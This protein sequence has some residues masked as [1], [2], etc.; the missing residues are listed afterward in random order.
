MSTLKLFGVVVP[1]RPPFYKILHTRH[2]QFPREY[3]FK[4]PAPAQLI[5]NL[6]RDVS[7]DAA[8]KIAV[9]LAWC[10][11]RRISDVVARFA[12]TFDPLFT[13][14]SSDIT[15]IVDGGHRYA[16]I[17]LPRSKS[18]PFN[19]GGTAFLAASTSRF[20]LCPVAFLESFLQ[21]RHSTSR[22]QPLC[23]LPSGKLVTY[24][25]VMDAIKA[26]AALLGLSAKSFATQ[27]LRIGGSTALSSAGCSIEDIML[28]GQWKSSACLRYLRQSR[29]RITRCAKALSLPA[30]VSSSLRPLDVLLTSRTRRPAYAI[31][32]LQ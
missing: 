22:S 7:V 15:F 29:K 32:D 3:N 13:L 11:T 5:T 30:E 23:V 28:A 8:V 20:S 1:P 4:Q 24:P 10:L 21:L 19:Q 27:S 12:T 31:A 14:M 18:D 26:H 9:L 25:I 2:K 16:Q 6:M 17:V